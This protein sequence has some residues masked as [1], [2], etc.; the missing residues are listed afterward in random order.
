MSLLTAGSCALD[1][2]LLRSLAVGFGLL[3]IGLAAGAL[4]LRRV[5]HYIISRQ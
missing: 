1:T 5:L 2:E 4:W 3:F